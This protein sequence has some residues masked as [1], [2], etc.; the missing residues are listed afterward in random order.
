MIYLY[1]KTHRITGL[2][3]LGKTSSNDPHLYPGSGKRWRAHLEKYG[4]NFDTEVLLES[5]DPVKIKEAGLHYSKLWNIVEDTNWAN[6]KPESGDGGTFTH[7]EE[8]KEKIG[9]AS[10]GK[11]SPYKGMRYED[12]QKDPS[13]ASDRKR[14][15]SKWMTEQNPFKGKTHSEETKIKMKESAQKRANLTDEE[16]KEIWG[17]LKGKPWSKARRLAQQNRKKTK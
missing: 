16:K 15:Q 12:I 5:N 14:N 2:R 4:Y 13:K 9:I 11:P 1:I 17:G 10:R 3:Y 6:L 8:A 7:T